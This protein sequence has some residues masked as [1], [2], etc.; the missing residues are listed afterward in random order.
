METILKTDEEMKK[1]VN[2]RIKEYTQDA[3]V[4]LKNEPLLY[5]SYQAID[6]ALR[7]FWGYETKDDYTI[8]GADGSF[9]ES[10][11]HE[12]LPALSLNGI[13]TIGLVGLYIT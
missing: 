8:E 6:Y 1:Y 10:Y 11:T 7:E 13:A 9:R 4:G 3:I 2:D 5:T 12:T